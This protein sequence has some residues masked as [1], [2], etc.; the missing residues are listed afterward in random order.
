MENRM[1]RP[2]LII[3]VG[4][5]DGQDTAFYLA[6]GFDVVAIEANPGLV[7]A[8]RDRFA[9]EID[10]GRLQIIPVA[11]AE[12]AG[13]LPL[14]ICDD[15]SIWSSMS[16]A[17]IERNESMAGVKYHYVDVPT[18]T[19]ESILE[20]VGVPHY[21]K[22]DIEG[23]DMIC[24]RALKHLDSVPDFISIESCVSSPPGSFELVFD[25]LS[26]LWE[27]GYR[28]FAYVDQTKIPRHKPPNPPREGRFVDATFTANCT[29]LFGEELPV[30]WETI[31][32]AVRRGQALHRR[33]NLTG[34]G[35]Q[36][37]RMVQRTVSSPLL[38][39]K[40]HPVAQRVAGITAGLFG[41][42]KW[43]DLHARLD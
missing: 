32:K 26:T 14:A 40:D 17:F 42:F 30:R 2:N 18:Q 38:D 23:S 19:F 5:H 9:S 41:L 21:L 10:S 25:E 22:V 11:V 37:T 7:E 13:T 6:K 1:K 24:V 33:Y 20:E 39:L 27:L 16:D 4:M 35:G 3:D 15:Q 36:A 8:A 12:T 28:R 34:F 29:G 43:Y 31:D